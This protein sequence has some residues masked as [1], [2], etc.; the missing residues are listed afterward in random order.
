M[1][2]HLLILFLAAGMAFAAV[3]QTSE[4]RSDDPALESRLRDLGEQLRCVVCQNQ[5]IA[6]SEA[7]LAKDMRNVV[8]Q[9]VAAGDTDAEVLYYMSERYGDFVLMT[10]PFQ[11]NTL[12]AWL[13]PLGLLVIVVLY[14]FL[15]RPGQRDA[16][17]VTSDLS[18]EDRA[19]A[20]ALLERKE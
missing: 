19:R 4:P 20:R 16:Q 8:R 5:T 6:N 18:P 17:P 13:L 12:I 3:A 7:P 1:I 10:P 15:R 11:A 14:L 9:R 2:R